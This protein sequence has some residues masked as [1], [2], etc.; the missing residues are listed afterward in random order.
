MSRGRKYSSCNQSDHNLVEERKQEKQKISECNARKKNKTVRELF[1]AQGLTCTQKKVTIFSSVGGVK[2][3]CQE[4]ITVNCKEHKLGK[5]KP[6]QDA[7]ETHCNT[8]HEDFG[9]PEQIINHY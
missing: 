3:V 6:G 5:V 2:E 8:A 4:V 1:A 9:G 7:A